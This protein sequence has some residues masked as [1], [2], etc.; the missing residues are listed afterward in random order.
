MT[1]NVAA[2]AP[3]ANPDAYA[4]T[5]GTTLTVPAATG[6]LANDTDPNGLPLTAAVDATRPA[7][8]SPSTPTGR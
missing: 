2:G 8:P 4:T 1:V 5:A 3:V 7:G 6:V